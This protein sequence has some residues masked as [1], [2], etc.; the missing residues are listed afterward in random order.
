MTDELLAPVGPK[1]ILVR[2]INNLLSIATREDDAPAMHRYLDAMLAVDPD[3][4]RERVMRMLVAKRLGRNTGVPTVP[5][6]GPQGFNPGH[7]VALHRE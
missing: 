5:P 1:A 7:R 4:G 2:M 3:A 6:W